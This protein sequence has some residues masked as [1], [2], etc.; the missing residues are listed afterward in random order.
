MAKYESPR[1]PALGFYVDGV[2]RRFSGGHYATDD[3]AEIAVLDALIDV[4]RADSAEKAPP[5]AV[6]AKKQPED[7]QKDVEPAE[8][9]EKPAP[10]PRK[11]GANASAK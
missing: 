8:V 10:K 4:R 6:E 9:P 7:P 1:Y 5:V 2:F 3:P 11:A